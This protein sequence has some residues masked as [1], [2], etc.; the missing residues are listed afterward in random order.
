MNELKISDEAHF[1]ASQNAYV[2]E[3]YFGEL[4]NDGEGSI[5]YGYDSD[6]IG[7]KSRAISIK[8]NGACFAYVIS[9]EVSALVCGKYNNLS[10]GQWFSTKNGLAV[11]LKSSDAKLIVVQRLGFDGVDLIGEVEESGGRLKYI[12][13][14]TDSLLFHPP[15]LGDPCLNALYMPEGIDQTMHT[16]PSTRMG[17]IFSGTGNAKTPETEIPLKTG[18]IFYLKTDQAHSFRTDKSG[19]YMKIIAYHPDSDFGPKGDDHPMINRTIVDGV[20]ASEL[21]D[22]R[23][24]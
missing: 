1:K 9:G 3:K 23:T 6:H 2:F 4:V 22:I 21:D 7:K 19:D 14:C 10:K 8:S 5:L 20:S 24:K 15:Q 17:C 12:D 16:H 18:D 13:G 11:V